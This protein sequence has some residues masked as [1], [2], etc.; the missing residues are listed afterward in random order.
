LQEITSNYDEVVGFCSGV[1]PALVV[2]TSTSIEDF[3]QGSD[4]AVRLAF[5]IGYRVAS[6]CEDRAGPQW[7]ARPWSIALSGLKEED[8]VR[9]NSKVGTKAM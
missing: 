5:W 8:V 9:F 2:A 1:I 4:N 7:R 3:I 6:F